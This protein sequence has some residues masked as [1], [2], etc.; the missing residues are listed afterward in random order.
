MTTDM[1]A[2]LAR[3][4]A[5][6][7]ALDGNAISPLRVDYRD[8]Q[9]PQRER[10]ERYI[11][12]IF[13]AAY[14]A[15]VLEFLPLLVFL[16]QDSDL[17]AALG[18]RCAREGS[19]FCEAYLPH[20]V[21]QHVRESFGRRVNRSQV[22][23]LGNLVSSQPG[24]AVALY[25][26]VVAALGQAGISHLLFAANRAVRLSIKR[27]GFVTREICAADPA[28]LQGRS[29]MWGSYYD[30]DPKVVLA[31]IRQA[32]EHGRNHPAIAGLWQRETLAIA[33]L[34]DAIRSQR[35]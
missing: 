23:E 34:A 28:C 16:E 9:S 15:S 24:Q 11:A 19:L 25:L 21:E 22:M 32:V 5:A 10:V 13:S 14:R 1:Q 7:A 29:Q 8:A 18:L 12:A 2:R 35:V 3:Q 33:S 17:Q 30:G 31:D 27:C 20:P 4:P 26:L 6:P